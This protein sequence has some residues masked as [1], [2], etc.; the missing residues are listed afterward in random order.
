MNEP[1]GIIRQY[2]ESHHRI[3][4][5]IALGWELWKIRRELGISQ[6]RLTLLMSDPA[7]QELVAYKSQKIQ[8]KIDKEMDL[9]AT[10]AVANML[11]SELAV[12]DAIEEHFDPDGQKISVSMLNKLSQDRADRFGYSKHQTMKVEHDFASSLDRAIAR[13][14]MKQIEAQPVIEAEVVEEK[15][16]A[17]LTLPVARPE[18]A[19]EPEVRFTKPLPRAPSFVKPI[20]KLA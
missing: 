11:Q 9:Y 13:S 12:A 15:A 8:E 20:R 18:P 7:F 10:T 2:R 3:A 14:G 4:E 5:L 6:R 16:Q 1:I 19:E 17:P